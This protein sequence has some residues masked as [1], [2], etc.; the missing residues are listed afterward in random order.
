MEL[1]YRDPMVVP[2]IILGI[3]ATILGITFLPALAVAAIAFLTGRKLLTR[4]QWGLILVASTI[5]V[6]LTAGKTFGSYF[7]WYPQIFG[8]ENLVEGIS[9]TNLTTPVWLPPLAVLSLGLVLAGVTGIILGDE[10]TIS[11]MSPMKT[12]SKSSVVPRDHKKVRSKLIKKAPPLEYIP[13]QRDGAPEPKGPKQNPKNLRLPLGRDQDGRLVWLSEKEIKTH[14]VILG[15]TGS[16]K[17]ETIKW[18]AGALLDM[19]YSVLI[20]DLKEDLVGLREFTRGYAYV[21]GTPYQEVALSDNDS[22]WWLNAISGVSADAAADAVIGQQEYDDQYHQSM[23]RRAAGQVNKL[24]F[25]AHELWPDRF[26]EPSIYLLGSILAKDMFKETKVMLAEVTA[27]I[28][29]DLAHELYSALFQRDDTLLKEA[30]SFGMRLVNLYDT[31]AGRNVLNEGVTSDG[32]PKRPID[33]TQPGLTYIGASSLAYPELAGTVASAVLTRVNVM[34]ADVAAGR[35]G[36]VPRKRAIIVDEANFVN[37]R[38]LLN[39]LSRAR[40]A[41]IT[42]WVATQSANDFIDKDGD[43][44]ARLATNINVSI[45]GKQT[46]PGAAELAAEFIGNEV[47]QSTTR[48]V[49]DG[50]VEESGSLKEDKDYIVPPEDLRSFEEGEMIIRTNAQINWVQVPMRNGEL[51]AYQAA[52]SP[53]PVVK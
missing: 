12:V 9:N 16:G 8:L 48:K 17:T 24:I 45:F 44:W 1:R 32:E 13:V 25:H 6:I 33:V 2:K 18:L 47:K 19:G 22:K 38:I 37:R 30:Q 41:G 7:L 20:L 42:A 5:G 31:T 4:L 26:P 34:A 29:H 27:H 53:P 46:A 52:G 10:G 11:T 49:V 43:D 51:E 36:A 21:H 35:N 3:L 50:Y 15:S 23:N 14:G 40:S 39:L 28:G